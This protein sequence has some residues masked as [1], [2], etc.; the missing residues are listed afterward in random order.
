MGYSPKGHKELDMTKPLNVRTCTH[1]HTIASYYGLSV[2]IFIS[3]F[4]SNQ[5]EVGGKGQGTTFKR[6][7]G[8]R[9]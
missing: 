4:K 3:V 9:T 5:T 7:N 6:M 8:H 1:T 2:E